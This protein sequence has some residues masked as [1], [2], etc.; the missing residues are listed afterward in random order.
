MEIENLA[1][2]TRIIIT[3]G[4]EAKKDIVL[5]SGI[6]ILRLQ[7]LARRR[8]KGARNAVA[9][10]AASVRALPPPAAHNGSAMRGKRGRPQWQLRL[11]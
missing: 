6:R 10:P 11:L 7:N 8:T 4:S 2:E 1:V 5:A 3:D 9:A